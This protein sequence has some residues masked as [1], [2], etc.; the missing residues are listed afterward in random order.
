MTDRDEVMLSGVLS[1]PCVD[2][3]RP[4]AV[5]ASSVHTAP[6]EWHYCLHGRGE[7]NVK[8]TLSVNPANAGLTVQSME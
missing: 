5:L 6:I 2:N 8:K 3:S 1:K 4:T 7:M